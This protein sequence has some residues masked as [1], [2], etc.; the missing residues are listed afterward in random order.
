[1]FSSS[2]GKRMRLLLF[3]MPVLCVC[4]VFMV[5]ICHISAQSQGDE[6][7]EYGKVYEFDTNLN[8]DFYVHVKV[9]GDTFTLSGRFAEGNMVKDAYVNMNGGLPLGRRKV[10]MDRSTGMFAAEIT[11][12][13]NVNT[14]GYLYVVLDEGQY[15]LRLYHDES[16]WY[17][18][19]NDLDRKTMD[20]VKKNIDVS[21]EVSAMYVSDTL[22]RDEAVYAVNEIKRIAEEVTAGIS[23]EYDKAKALSRWVAD[24]VAYDKDAYSTEVNNATISLY[25]VLTKRRT[26]CSGYANLFGALCEA[27]GI[28]AV[29]IHGSNVDYSNGGYE[30]LENVTL[31][32]EYSAFWCDDQNRWVYVDTT[33]DSE[34]IY[35]NGVRTE[36]MSS[37]LYFDMSPF[38]FSFVHR[39]DYAQQRTYLNAVSYIDSLTPA[40][41]TAAAATATTTA[42]ISAAESSAASAPQ[43]PEQTSAQTQAVDIIT[44][45]EE[46]APETQT[47]ADTAPQTI[48]EEETSPELEA[49]PENVDQ[50]VTQ[51]VTEEAR[52]DTVTDER[53]TSAV[54]TEQDE[55]DDVSPESETARS[56]AQPA[57][58]TEEPPEDYTMYYILIAAGVVSCGI[59]AVIL[60]HN[61][62]RK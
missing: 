6:N 55:T 59:A 48:A 39:G 22:N 46:T 58:P 19:D 23:G 10:N 9:E 57:K 60:R 4:I 12:A 1:M 3:F 7:F 53:V 37:G 40:A 13:C 45:A 17:F 31:T 41:T 26:V 38:A 30:Q 42:T 54:T 49:A 43:T 47:A 16:G 15:N 28:K 25:N 61:I 14:I 2:S 35:E 11:Q 29:T 21:D 52:T 33:W 18:P 36:I 8:P 20:V 62:K 32:H 44:V 50:T 34:N 24:N 5:Y 51:T 27:A 56:A